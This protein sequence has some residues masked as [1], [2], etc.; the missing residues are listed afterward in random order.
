MSAEED[1]DFQTDTSKMIGRG[2]RDRFRHEYSPRFEGK[3]HFGRND[4]PPSR[5]LW[6]GNLSPHIS[7]NHLSEQFLRF[8]DLDNIAFIPGRSYAFVNFKK[9]E[10]AAIAMRALQGFVV[11]GLPLKIEFTKGERSSHGEDYPQSRAERRSTVHGESFPRRDSRVYHASPERHH[12]DRFKGDK[13]A[14]PSEVLWIGFPSFLNVDEVTLRKAFS[15][16]GEIEKTTA[17]PGRSYAFVQ[18]KSVVAACRAK[19]A[20]QGK[21]FNNPRVNICFAKSELGLS[22]RGR[23]ST[24]VPFQTHISSKDHPG[25]GRPVIEDIQQ[26]RSFGS[27]FSELTTSGSRF[28]SDSEM[29][30]DLGAFSFSRNNSLRT[31]AGGTFEQVRWQGLGLERGFSEDIYEHHKGSPAV[32]SD[33]LKRDFPPERPSRRSPFFEE[34]W[35]SPDDAFPVREAKKLKIGPFPDKELPEYPFSDLEQDK[36]RFGLPK[37]FPDLPVREAFDNNFESG[38]FSSRQNPDYLR[39]LTRSLSDRDDPWKTHDGFE[40]GSAPLPSKPV[41]QQRFTPESHRSPLNEE[42][43]WEG[44]I[45]KG[46]TPVCRAR[47]FPVGKVLDVMLPEFL[48]CTARTGLDML[49]KHFYQAANFW[50]VFFVPGSDA[51]IVFY[52]EF[53]NYLG[54]KQRAAVA[55]LSEKTTL[56]L[57]PPSD[58]SEKVLKVPGKVSISGVI[59]RFQH[60]NSNFVSLPHPLETMDSKLPSS[61][62]GNRGNDGASFHEDLSFPKPTSPNFRTSSSWGQTYASSSSDLFPS[63]SSPLPS[64][65]KQVVANPPF[66]EKVSDSFTEGSRYDQLPRQTPR[67]PSNWSPHQTHN[68]NSNISFPSHSA[69]SHP[70]DGSTLPEYLSA[71]PNVV[72]GSNS[73]QYTPGSS[74]FTLYGAKPQI[75]QPETKPQVSAPAP[76][77]PEQLAQLAALLGQRQQLGSASVSSI[78]ED[79]NLSNL[80]NIPEQEFKSS[81]KDLQNHA[82]AST[83]S[84]ACQFGQMQQQAT[85]FSAVPQSQMELQS[86]IPSHEGNQQQQ[87]HTQDESEG[88]PQ[89]RLQATLQLAAALL[90][91]L[92]QQAKTSD[93]R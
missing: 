64:F 10:D 66:T 16:F 43:K 34:S 70:F 26:D 45:A 78:G 56:F 13:G 71:K 65:R 60:P 48:N 89:K 76:L 72:Q 2:G 86:G 14:E 92:Q 18:F 15:P 77:Q 82:S 93:K 38:P 88:D 41:N 63:A 62:V 67:L 53:M 83:N 50:V 32:D 20:L 85:N 24:D 40:A 47:C 1:E 36:Q 57:V 84:L 69:S 80:P 22:E 58:F 28:I 51:D 90:Q 68:S 12:S 19:E 5:H 37:A 23:N 4:A 54:E 11:A 9:D 25:P 30:R 91:Q 61:L 75:S 8:G 52:N 33:P 49:A 44:T 39:S 74:G 55:K 29:S 81:Q 27:S 59:L 3:S 42:W 31:G 6:V 21:L 79:R 73:S 87:N 35:D 46:G 7:E 17:F